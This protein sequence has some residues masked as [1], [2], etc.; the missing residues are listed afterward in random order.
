MKPTSLKRNPSIGRRG[1]WLSL[2]VVA[3]LIA[4]CDNDNGND[5]G[6]DSDSDSGDDGGGPKPDVAYDGAIS[7]GDV[8]SGSDASIDAA[9]P[10][11]ALPDA[12]PSD[13]A[14]QPDDAAGDGPPM[15][16][17]VTEPDMARPDDAA[18]ADATLDPDVAILVDA[19]PEPD[20]PERADLGGV[21]DSAPPDIQPIPDVFRPDARPADATPPECFEH[22]D[23]LDHR[24]CEQ[25]ACVEGAGGPLFG[26]VILNEVLIDGTTD[27]DANGDGDIHA[28]DDE[29]IEIVNLSDEAVDLSGLMLVE[30]DLVVPRHT[31]EPGSVL[32][33]GRALVVFGGGQPSEDL[34]S[35]A[36]G[37]QFVV[38]NPDDPAFSNGLN[39]DDDGDVL[40]LLDADRRHV[41]MFAYGD[42]CDAED[43]ACWPAVSDRSL[44][45]TPDLMGAFAP[46]EDTLFSPGTLADGEPFVP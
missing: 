13:V 38:A 35:E 24:R 27:E 15:V 25:G 18:P 22:V 5:N 8:D 2:V 32:E 40:R 17:A 42:A 20:V 37:T 21:S 46:H 36:P 9:P 43:P 12:E 23:C 10:D 44:T 39:L 26:V 1:L 4:A 16:D 14:P 7:D 3:S 30:S 19:T 6:N 45:R 33:G 28:T 31:F 41:F 29:F 34:E 11:A